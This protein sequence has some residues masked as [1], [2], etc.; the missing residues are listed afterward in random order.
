MHEFYYY[1]PDHGFKTGIS[2]T[3]MISAVK[4]ERA[5][6]WLDIFDIDDNDIDL[7][8]NA[9]NLHP[10]TVE[11]F[12]MPNARPKIEEFPDYLFL[13]MFTMQSGNNN[14]NNKFGAAELDC[15]LGKNFLVT[16]HSEKLNTIC[17]CKERVKKQSPMIMHGADMLLYSILDACV[18][19]YTPIIHEFDNMVDEMSDDLFKAPS[20][21]TLKKIYS[22]KNEV[23]H[24]RRLI[25]P[26][27]DVIGLLSRGTNKFITQS[28]IIFFRNIFDSMARFNDIIGASR[29]VIS[30]AME[31][32]TSIVSNRLNEIMKTLTIM[33]TIMMPLTLLASIYGMNFKY[34]PELEHKFGYPAVILIMFTTLILM[35]A[36]FKRKKWL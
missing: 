13:V 16:F 23:M 26:Q 2:S 6:S 17:V 9:F 15:C 28:N 22:L 27:A 3:E 18:D 32:Y 1:H 20:Q 14:Q 7:L 24:L 35:L 33:A 29:D 21:D 30:G 4:D 19:N 10:L 12:I 36:F 31:A 8:T 34:M 11:D 5:V 25:G